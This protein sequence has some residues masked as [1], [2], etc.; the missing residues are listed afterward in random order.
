MIRAREVK[1]IGPEGELI[2][3]RPINEAFSLAEEHGLDLVEVAPNEQPPV[4]KIMDFGKYKYKL[5]KKTQQGRKKQRMVQVKEVKFTPKTDEHDYLFKVKHARRFLT[6][7]NKTKITIV[8]RGRELLHAN[9]GEKMLERM[10]N[11][12]NDI[13]AVE[14]K[15]KQEGKNLV[16]IL[17]PKSVKPS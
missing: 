4:C 16:M 10:V 17:M 2:G 6:E 7:G 15:P 9:I 14:Q 1:V 3:V 12:L 8:F 5:S 11:D 13:G